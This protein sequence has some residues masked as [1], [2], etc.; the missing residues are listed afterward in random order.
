MCCRR[1]VLQALVIFDVVDEEV[2]MADSMLAEQLGQVALL[3]DNAAKDN[4]TPQ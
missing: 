2:T 3:L 1:E 4:H